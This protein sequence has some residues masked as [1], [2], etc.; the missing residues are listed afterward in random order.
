MSSV[1]NTKSEGQVT[2]SRPREVGA[3]EINEQQ[4]SIAS[5]LEAK[6]S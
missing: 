3:A 5:D 4:W 1:W 2:E 6:G